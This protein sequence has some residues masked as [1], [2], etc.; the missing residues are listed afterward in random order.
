MRVAMIVGRFPV[1]SETF[2]LN[3][4]T[5]LIDRGHEVDIYTEAPG[6]TAKM[7]PNVEKYQLLERTQCM[8]MPQ[9]RL[10]RFLKGIW[11]FSINYQKNPALLVRSLNVFK[12]GKDAASLRL[13]Y[14]A[15]SVLPFLDQGT[16][17]IIHC[18]FGTFGFLGIAFRMMAAPK[19]KL[20]V[21]FRGYDISWYLQW[22]GDDV[23]DR[24][25]KVVDVCLPNC[26]YFKQRLIKLGADENKIVI[27]RSG[28]DCS[29]FIFTARHL[30][31]DGRIRIVTTGRLVEKK[32][33]EYGIRAV[34]KL[35]KLH[36][37]LEYNII[38][39]GPLKEDLQQLIQELNVGETVKLLGRMQQQELIKILDNS[40]IFIAP[41]VTAKN[42]DQ[43]APVNV[44]K[45][46]MAMGLPVIG[47]QHG[48][49][50]E[51]IEDGIAG[52]L[53]PERDADT[54]AEKLGYLIEH[55]EVW[56]EMGRAG[57]TYVEEHYDLNK[58][59]DLLVASYQ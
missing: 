2:V 54:L 34:A 11:L 7:H 24:L 53:V 39:D 17:D 58:L 36:S 48:G 50:P 59:N 15:V 14:A 30:P 19:G 5:G 3:Q 25:F 18:Q 10:L 55:P 4:V 28:I 8:G 23:Y 31:P 6:E 44:L 57:R 22:A 32:G 26:D 16:Y 13:L 49:I 1:L 35:T 47:T 51:L 43:D 40:H 29:K 33:L 27:M 52:F 38:G 45:E 56:P 21:S 37:N 42:G 12:Y 20:V 9:N 46:A 41:C